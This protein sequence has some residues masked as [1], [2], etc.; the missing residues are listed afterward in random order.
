VP[1]GEACDVCTEPFKDGDRGIVLPYSGT[2][3]EE[4]D[5]I[6]YHLPCFKRLIGP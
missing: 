3:G 2:I 5:E 6:A 1:I 4:D